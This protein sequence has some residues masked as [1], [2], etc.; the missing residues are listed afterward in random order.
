MDVERESGGVVE[1]KGGT[2]GKEKNRKE[3][4]M[5]ENLRRKK[6]RIVEGKRREEVR[7]E[8]GRERG[9]DRKNV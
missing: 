5:K 2:I 9:R 4:C 3:N 6:S 1:L 8:D 7:G